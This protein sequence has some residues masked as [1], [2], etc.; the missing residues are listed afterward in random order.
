MCRKPVFLKTAVNSISYLLIIF[1]TAYFD[2]SKHG[3]QNCLAKILTSRCLKSYC[4]DLCLSVSH[5]SPRVLQSLTVSEH[6]TMQ[7]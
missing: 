2:L 5:S 3:L 1:S 4:V 7:W 6:Y